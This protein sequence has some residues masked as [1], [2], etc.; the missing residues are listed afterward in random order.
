MTAPDQVKP[1]VYTAFDCLELS[2][3]VR[4]MTR[5]RKTPFV[6]IH[7]TP[8]TRDELRADTLA[9]TAP[10]GRRVSMS[11]VLGAALSIARR[12]EQEWAQLLADPG[13]SEAP[14]SD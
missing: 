13:V 9:L 5:G 6:A 14:D 10:A 8:A 2:A 7:V 1:D 4:P 12:H 11:D 3:T